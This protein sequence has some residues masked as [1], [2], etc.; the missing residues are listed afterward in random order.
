MK[1]KEM[2]YIKDD[3]IYFTPY[4]REY[5]ITE[6]IQTLILELKKLKEKQTYG[7]YRLL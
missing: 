7:L 3:Q 5:D 1:T 2:I 6:H 4:L